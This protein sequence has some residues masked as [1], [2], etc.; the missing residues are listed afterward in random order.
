MQKPA[1]PTTK[2]CTANGR[3]RHERFM[4]KTAV[5]KIHKSLSVI[6]IRYG[7]IWY[8]K[9]YDWNRDKNETMK[10]QR[11]ISFEE[12]VFHIDAG[13]ELDVYPHPN[14][15]Q[16]PAQMILVVAINGYAYLIPFIES[17]DSLFLKTIIPSRKAT[18]LYLRG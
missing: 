6:G 13:D 11:G 17:E 8:M 7:T 15:E 4:G 12:V 5:S 10:K 18:K 3:S 9:S 16:Y 14:Q 1:V 2:V